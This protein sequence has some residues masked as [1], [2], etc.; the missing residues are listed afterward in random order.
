MQVYVY[1]ISRC[2]NINK[3]VTL[4]YRVS[5]GGVARNIP[6]EWTAALFGPV[7]HSLPGSIGPWS[8]FTY[9]RFESLDTGDLLFEFRIG[10]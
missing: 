5:L 3:D 2:T 6:T 10:K 7:V 9:P 1:R 4:N 8:P